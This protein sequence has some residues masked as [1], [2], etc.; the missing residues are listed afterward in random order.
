MEILAGPY[1]PATDITSTGVIL[2]WSMGVFISREH[3]KYTRMCGGKQY[4]FELL[5]SHRSL[6]FP[7]AII[8][9]EYILLI[10]LI[11]FNYLQLSANPMPFFRNGINSLYFQKNQ[12]A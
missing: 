9:V 10:L 4:F 11:C 6:L 2:Y 7:A 5:L 8:L 1:P 12:N 3:I